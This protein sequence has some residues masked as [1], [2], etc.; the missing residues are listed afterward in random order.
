MTDKPLNKLAKKIR[1]I[2]EENGFR[3]TQEKDFH[4]GDRLPCNIALIHSEVSELLEAYR[5]D[6]RE[7][8]KEEY[9]DILIRV[10]DSAGGMKDFDIDEEL[11]KKLEINKTRGFMHGGKKC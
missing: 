11:E 6:N 4:A 9:V 2:N 5:N 8:M 10:L 3:I 1:K 7:N